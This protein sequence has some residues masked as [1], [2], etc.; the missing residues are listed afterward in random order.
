VSGP[1]AAKFMQYALETFGSAYFTE[2]REAFRNLHLARF[3]KI[4]TA[5]V[6]DPLSDALPARLDR[7][8]LDETERLL[9]AF[10]IS[11]HG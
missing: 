8:A 10:D 7:E 11:N 9:T 1:L 3:D 5:S 4:T 2:K 6:L